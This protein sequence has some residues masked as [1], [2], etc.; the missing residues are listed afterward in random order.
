MDNYF[1]ITKEYKPTISDESNEM[2][3][4]PSVTNLANSPI[5]VCIYC[6]MGLVELVEGG[7]GVINLYLY[8]CAFTYISCISMFLKINRKQSE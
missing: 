7:G 5:T 6:R 3:Q 8:Y 2:H 4:S 1:I